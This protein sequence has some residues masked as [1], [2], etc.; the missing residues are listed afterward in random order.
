MLNDKIL[1]CQNKNQTF[2]LFTRHHS[3]VVRA[4]QQQQHKK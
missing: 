4:E 3:V 2:R 1:F